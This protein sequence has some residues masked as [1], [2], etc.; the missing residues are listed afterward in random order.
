MITLSALL[1]ILLLAF[2]GIGIYR[3]VRRLRPSNAR[4]YD[5][6]MAQLSWWDTSP[7]RGLG[8]RA[9][10]RGPYDPVDVDDM[11]N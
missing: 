2:A 11:T 6:A 10:P 5:D 8:D 1:N 9:T 3:L 4:N 7:R